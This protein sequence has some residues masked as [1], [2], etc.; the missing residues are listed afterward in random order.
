MLRTISLFVLIFLAAALCVHSQETRVEV[1]KISISEEA[2]NA[3]PELRAAH[4][5][6]LWIVLPD[7]AESLSAIFGSDETIL[8]IKTS[9]T[10]WQNDYCGFLASSSNAGLLQLHPEMHYDSWVT[11]GIENSKSSGSMYFLESPGQPWA[12]NFE[13]GQALTMSDSIGGSWFALPGQ[14]NTLPREGKVLIG[15]FTTE[16]AFEGVVN[17][18]YLT[19]SGEAVLVNGLTF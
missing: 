19:K 17:C 10:F 8:E 18:Q 11:I 12:V 7:S 9:T 15:Q 16:G 6:R 5:Y 13:A 14:P 1:E 4:C 3:M 2:K